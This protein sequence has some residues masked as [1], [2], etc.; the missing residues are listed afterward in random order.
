MFGQPFME[1]VFQLMR[2]PQQHI[3]SPIRAVRLC[4]FKQAFKLGL[5]QRRN[6]GRG[7][8]GHWHAGLA[9]GFDGLIA[10]VRGCRARLHQAREFAVLRRDGHPNSA[11]L[12][13]RHWRNQV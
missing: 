5:V 2:Q 9:Q 3:A 4:R 1:Q 8:D 11:K 7:H 13:L 12:L 10:F 6:D